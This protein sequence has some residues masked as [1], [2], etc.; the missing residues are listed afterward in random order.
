MLPAKAFA[1]TGPV[2]CFAKQVDSGNRVDRFFCQNCGSALYSVNSSMPDIVFPRASGLD[3]PEI[4]APQITVYA[5]RA[6]SWDRIAPDLPSWPEMPQSP[7][8]VAEG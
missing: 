2:S 7:P 4:A 3:D 5:S 6:A 1:I 8:A